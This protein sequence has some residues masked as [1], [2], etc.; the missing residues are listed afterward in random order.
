[1]HCAE[2][3]HQEEIFL[4]MREVG[5]LKHDK[6]WLETTSKEW[7]I[8]DVKSFESFG[9]SIFQNCSNFQ[10]K[11]IWIFLELYRSKGALLELG[12]R[13]LKCKLFTLP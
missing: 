9:K 3:S 1:M 11:K 6:S 2:A 8:E 7:F 13:S 12:I 5:H 10:V 4:V